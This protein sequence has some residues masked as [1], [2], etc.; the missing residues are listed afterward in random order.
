MFLD[1]YLEKQ[2]ELEK[3]SDI[4]ED[5]KKEETVVTEGKI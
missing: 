4:S 3:K 2:T 5:E 1:T